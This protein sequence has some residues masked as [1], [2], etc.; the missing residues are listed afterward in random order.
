MII[1]KHIEKIIFLFEWTIKGRVYSK[2]ISHQN[3]GEYNSIL[4]LGF[5]FCFLF[6][7][8]NRSSWGSQLG[9]HLIQVDRTPNPTWVAGSPTQGDTRK[10]PE[11]QYLSKYGPDRKNWENRVAIK[12]KFFVVLLPYILLRYHFAVLQQY[13]YRSCSAIKLEDYDIWNN[14]MWTLCAPSSLCT[15]TKPCRLCNV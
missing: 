6:L 8:K 13:C 12:L 4:P 2:M 14:I 15:L 11:W 3:V 1:Y 10:S 9:G 7:C 5:V